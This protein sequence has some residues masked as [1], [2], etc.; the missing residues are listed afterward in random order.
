MGLY[1]QN[2]NILKAVRF[3]ILLRNFY[4]RKILVFEGRFSSYSGS[5]R[6]ELCSLS[7][8]LIFGKLPCN[9]CVHALTP[10]CENVEIPIDFIISCFD[11]MA[12]NND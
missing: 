10:L 7:P 4:A 3:Y 1:N 8:V 2:M 5:E 6:V 9:C 12:I 11:Y